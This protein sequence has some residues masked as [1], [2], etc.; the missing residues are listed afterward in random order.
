MRGKYNIATGIFEWGWSKDGGGELRSV[1]FRKNR[2]MINPIY[3]ERMLY[4]QDVTFPEL[5][6]VEIYVNFSSGSD[7]DVYSAVLPFNPVF[8]STV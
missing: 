7:I 3:P 8:T 6:S 5:G 1:Q 4:P 2:T